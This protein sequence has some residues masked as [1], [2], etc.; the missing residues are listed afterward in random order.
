MVR[1]CQTTFFLKPVKAK[2]RPDYVLIKDPVEAVSFDPNSLTTALDRYL[3][4]LN[5]VGQNLARDSTARVKIVGCN[6]DSGIETANLDLSERRAA[7]V[8][9]YLQEIWGIDGSRMDIETRNLPAN[10]TAMDLVGARPENQRV[11]IIY[12]ST[13]LQ[14]ALR[15]I[16]WL[17]QAAGAN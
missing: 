14:T 11:E 1:P 16:S 9:S 13:D 12:E 5:L 8:M 10:A 3:N 6:S 15:T 7:S 2:S 17:K 4:I